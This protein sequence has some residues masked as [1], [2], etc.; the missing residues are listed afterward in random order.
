M[1]TALN[2][3]LG[4]PSP[5]Y[6]DGLALYQPI[7]AVHIQELRNRVLN[8]WQSGGGVD[9]RWL[10]NDRLG[11][12]RMVFDQSG[13]LANVSRRE[14]LP[15]GEEL[16]AGVGGRTTGLGYTSSDGA[17]QKF[18]GYE[19][20][21]ETGLDYAQAR[22]YASTQG[23]FTS[24]DPLA[25]SARI[26]NPQTW[27]RYSYVL[28][29]PPKFVDP[30]GLAEKD[31]RRLLEEVM[32]KARNKKIDTE[33][34]N[35]V[36]PLAPLT[37]SA[38]FST[39]Y[40][41]ELNGNTETQAAY[42][43][44]VRTYGKNAAGSVY[45]SWTRY[46][47][48][49]FLNTVAAIQDAFGDKVAWDGVKF[50]GWYEHTRNGL[51]YGIKLTG[52]TDKMLEDAGLGEAPPFGRRSPREIRTATLEATREGNVVDFDIDLY[53]AKPQTRIFGPVPV[54][55][56][57]HKAEVDWNRSNGATT[58]PADVTRALNGRQVRSGVTAP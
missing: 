53:N 54:I 40:F 20:D 28:N 38:L 5:A 3:A 57:K 49:V 41:S 16:G 6:A 18:T 24:I 58:H 43:L 11:T 29:N 17:R 12:P 39:P 46:D 37:G 13:S 23:R 50:V 2:E 15:F 30:D 26:R 34:R 36:S 1:R 21:A 22:Y 19:R 56:S 7:L 25:A 4:P 8:A 44:L 42:D 45:A 31:P 32:E 47:R 10:V 33:I 27:N 9:I 48:A 52:V 51:S 55:F 35:P 14:Y